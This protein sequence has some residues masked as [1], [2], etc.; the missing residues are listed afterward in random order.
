MASERRLR[1]RVTTARRTA[2]TPASCV[3][4]VAAAAAG[5]GRGGRL[6]ALRVAALK[7]SCVFPGQAAEVK[8]RRRA[9]QAESCAR[10][11]ATLGCVGATRRA[12]RTGRVGRAGQ[13]VLRCGVVWCRVGWCGVVPVH[14]D[15][16]DNA[17]G[18]CSCQPLVPVVTCRTCTAATPQSVRVLARSQRF[19]SGLGA[20]E[21]S[22]SEY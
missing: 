12:A 2:T 15:N 20:R 13:H 21:S 18:C 1:P 11:V 22:N 16:A 14:W 6:P 7:Q 10:R 9:S 3:P 17:A 4:A 19:T 8:F 5:G